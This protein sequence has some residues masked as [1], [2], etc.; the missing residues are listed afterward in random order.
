MEISGNHLPALI[1]FVVGL[2]MVLLEF[3]VPGVIIVFFG[4]G[5][6]IVT[7]LAYFNILPTLE[8]QL[9]IFCISSIVLLIALRKWIRNKFTGHISDIQNPDENLDEF[10]G[11]PVKVLSDVL[12][13]QSSGR[14][15]FKGA[16]WSA[17]SDV[18]I[19]EGETATIEKV[20]G[21][22]LIIKRMEG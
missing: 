17:V 10:T 20:D 8:S 21:L 5:A 14:V 19:K 3:A 4:I 13:G 16:T 6:W 2:V 1:W 15:E 12:P 11:K 7:I 9:L 22:T 18:P